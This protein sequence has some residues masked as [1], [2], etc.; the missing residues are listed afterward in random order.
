MLSLL[1]LIIFLDTPPII[2]G[3][4]IALWVAV[5]WAIEVVIKSVY[6]SIS[7][8]VIL[9][10]YVVFFIAAPSVQFLMR[11]NDLLINTLP[12]DDLDIGLANFMLA[13]WL[14]MYQLSIIFLANKIKPIEN[15]SV[16][17]ILEMSANSV[18]SL[19]PVAI[20][21]AV[22][23][24]LFLRVLNEFG[25]NIHQSSL[26]EPQYFGLI[27]KKFLYV[28]P[29]SPFIILALKP[30]NHKSIILLFLLALIVFFF[31]NPLIEH[32]NGFGVAYLLMTWIFF[33]N[34]L[35]SNLR[36]ISFLMFV[37]L[38][39]FPIGALI[40]PSRYDNDTDYIAEFM[41]TFN[42]VHFDAWAHYVATFDYIKNNDLQ[43]GH[44]LISSIMFWVP[45]DF[46]STKGVSTGMLLGDYLMERYSF[47]FNNISCVFPAEFVIDFG[48]VG[49][50]LS[51]F[52]LGAATFLVDKIFYQGSFAAKL[53]SLYVSFN[54]LFIM[55]GPLL[56]SLAYT[57][58][59]ALSVYIGCLLTL[60]L[61]RFLK[62]R[63]IA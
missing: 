63:S 1:A 17:S 33:R 2:K 4:F 9:I 38:I 30:I 20:S 27:F 21:L 28:L 42:R 36:L 15:S 31:K 12:V 54:F 44:Q 22:F 10:F 59:G 47:W 45:R 34:Y 11:G 37:V 35:N 3:S 62:K 48:Y 13:I 52:L 60:R 5:A 40:S 46:W 56:P 19:A 24:L 49:I 55:R 23:F 25:F 50:P 18:R 58:G 61:D 51:A 41:Y 53:T 14:I 39:F 57:F 26:N 32:R 29:L 7:N 8:T 6:F 16:I 43:L